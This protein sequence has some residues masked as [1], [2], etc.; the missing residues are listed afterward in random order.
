MVVFWGNSPFSFISISV[1]WL[2]PADVSSESL[3]QMAPDP[4]GRWGPQ[5]AP[6]SLQKNICVGLSLHATLTG[7]THYLSS[8]S[9]PLNITH[10]QNSGVSLKPLMYV[11]SCS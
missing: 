7:Q 2:I 8:H 3:F 4:G 10:Y 11:T 9:R 5:K 6:G 1:T